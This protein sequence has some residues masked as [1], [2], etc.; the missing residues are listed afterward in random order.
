[1]N[2]GNVAE[3][4]PPLE[5]LQKEGSMLRTMGIDSGG[6]E[7]L[8]LLAQRAQSGDMTTSLPRSNRREDT[9][10]VEGAETVN[11]V[12]HVKDA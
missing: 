4:G 11:V 5:L 3:C 10:I 8:I 9:E 1:M 2:A 12:A 7:N 6:L